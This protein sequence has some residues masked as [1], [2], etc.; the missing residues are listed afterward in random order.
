MLIEK[1]IVYGFVPA[2]RGMR[3]PKDSWDRSDSIFIGGDRCTYSIN[4]CLAGPDVITEQEESITPPEWGSH[5]SAP[6]TPWI[7]PLD[8]SLCR[9]LIAGGSEH[10]KFLRQIIIWVDLTLSRAILQEL[11]TYKVATVRNSCSTMH[12]LGSAD[13]SLDDFEDGE[14]NREFLLVVIGWLNLLA[15]KMKKEKD[16]QYR[17]EMKALLPESFLQ[18]ITYSMSYETALNMYFQRR[19]H[20][21]REWREDNPD[22]ICSWIKSLPYMD[23]FISFATRNKVGESLLENNGF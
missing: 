23:K 13:L 22:S 6:E 21:M 2:L 20:R 11:D 19:N 16:F 18:K 4:G 7:G 5:I 3:N 17:R 15:Q 9:K 8:L 14:E 1:T 12:K 10:R